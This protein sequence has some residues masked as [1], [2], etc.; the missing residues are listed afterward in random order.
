MILT[1]F[2]GFLITQAAKSAVIFAV[3]S[4]MS[5]I[6]SASSPADLC[7]VAGR[8]AANSAGVPED[9]LR[10]LTLVETGRKKGKKFQPWPWTVN[11]EGK[12]RWFETSDEA[13]SYVYKHYKTG[14]RSFDVG[15]FQ[16]NFRW[17]G[18][19]FASIEEMFD[20]VANANYAAA[21]IKS[22]KTE[23]GTWT[24]AAGAYHSRTPK[25]AKKYS[26]KFDR[27]RSSLEPYEL[28]PSDTKT[29]A[30]A[31]EAKSNLRK[32]NVNSFPLLQGRIGGV[33]LGSLVPIAPN[34]R[35]RRLIDVAQGEPT[36]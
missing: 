3:L 32:R 35:L 10:A 2:T 26:E 9:V 17:H 28:K 33:T 27:L 12:G 19:A 36:R 20:P 16:I 23:M 8:E 14:A 24:A 30:L 18:Q 4:L 22:L 15:C 29:S 1:K 25:F 34:P 13:L 7:H 11:V 5:S 31:V 21:F 6:A